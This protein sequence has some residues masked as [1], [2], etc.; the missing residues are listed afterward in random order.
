MRGGFAVCVIM[1]WQAPHAALTALTQ[2]VRVR[3]VPG[4]RDMMV[5]MPVVQR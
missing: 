4:H 5:L 3:M 1:A 2:L